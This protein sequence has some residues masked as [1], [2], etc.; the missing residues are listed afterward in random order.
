MSMGMTSGSTERLVCCAVG[1]LA[2]AAAAA[3]LLSRRQAGTKARPTDD[4]VDLP[5]PNPDWK[6]EMQPT[7]PF[8]CEF[9]EVRIADMGVAPFGMFMSAMGP[10]MFHLVSTLSPEGVANLSPVCY[11]SAVSE[12]EPHIAMGITKRKGKPEPKDTQV[13]IDATGEFVLNVVSSWCCEAAEHCAKRGGPDVDEFQLGGFTKL[14]ST[15]VRPFRAK[16]TAVQLECK[17]VSFSDLDDANGVQASRVYL[18]KVT[19]IHFAKELM[20]DGRTVADPLIQLSKG[21]K[22]VLLINPNSRTIVNSAFGDTKARA[23]Y[24][25]E[26]EACSTTLDGMAKHGDPDGAAWAAFELALL[27]EESGRAST[28]VGAAGAH[29]HAARDEAARKLIGNHACAPGRGRPPCTR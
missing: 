29:A 28:A 6:P 2:G 21:L 22:P 18:A 23:T 12:D 3:A 7:S 13:N 15:T 26:F 9:H 1:A 19:A 17:V 25:A 24:A 8:S 20:A 11:I 10:R 16:E 14:P 4:F 27:H 5:P